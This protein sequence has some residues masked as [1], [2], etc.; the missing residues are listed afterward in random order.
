MLLQ[1]EAILF[2]SKC[3]KS[4]RRQGPKGRGLQ[5]SP[6]YLAGFKGRTKKGAGKGYRGSSG[7]SMLG[8]GEHRPPNLAQA[9]QIN[10]G[11]LDTVVLLLVDVIGSIVISLS[12]C[13]LPNDEGQGAPNIFS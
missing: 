11:Q 9:P 6:D 8:P 5:R 12:R 4:V 13:C 7:G 1:P 2:D 10:T 3:I